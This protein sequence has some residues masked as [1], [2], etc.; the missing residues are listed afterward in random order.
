MFPDI[1]F[2]IKFYSSCSHSGR[3]TVKYGGREGGRERG[4]FFAAFVQGV[5]VLM[6][7]G[8]R[9][10]AQK[11]WH[12]S[13]DAQF[14]MPTVFAGVFCWDTCVENQK[15]LPAHFVDGRHATRDCEYWLLCSLFHTKL[16]FLFVG[17]LLSTYPFSTTEAQARAA[18]A[19]I[20]KCCIPPCCVLFRFTRRASDQGEFFFRTTVGLSGAR[21]W[22]HTSGSTA[23]LVPRLLLVLSKLFTDS[24]HGLLVFLC[25]ADRNL[26]ARPNYLCQ[27]GPGAAQ[28]CLH[29]DRKRFNLRAG[30]GTG[31]GFSANMKSKLPCGD[32]R[33]QA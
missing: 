26:S 17:D 8:R 20:S 24:L 5:C 31:A 13:L 22:H 30:A 1:Y 10:P 14:C 21:A 6:V 2:F 28:W 3:S 16:F 4:S 25:D 23:Q 18:W 12:H 29:W 19:A 27:R 32:V 11:S 33:Y 9:A 7:S 15:T